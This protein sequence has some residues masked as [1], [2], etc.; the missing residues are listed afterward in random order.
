MVE[1]N[2][3]LDFDALKNPA[4]DNISDEAEEKR[5]DELD[6]KFSEIMEL[7]KQQDLLLGIPVT[8]YDAKLKN[9]YTLYPSGE[10][11]YGKE[12]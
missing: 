5:L 8:R 1:I 10:K 11:V 4:K 7:K 6:G 3:K 12:A 2:I 9:Y